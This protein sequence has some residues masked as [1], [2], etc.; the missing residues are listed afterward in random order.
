MDRELGKLSGRGTFFAGRSGCDS[1]LRDRICEQSARSG[2]RY[3]RDGNLSGLS[4]DDESADRCGGGGDDSFCDGRFE[5][6]DQTRADGVFGGKQ[7]DRIWLR[8]WF[9][10]ADG[11]LR[12]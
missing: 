5:R 11:R 6:D 7:F 8:R 2:L 1:N 9:Y 3:L 10:A 4:A 12:L